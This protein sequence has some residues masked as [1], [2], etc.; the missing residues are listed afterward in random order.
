M[1]DDKRATA[2]DPAA[3]AAE[4]DDALRALT[5]AHMPTAGDLLPLDVIESLQTGMDLLK[6]QVIPFPSERARA[7]QARGMQ[8]VDLDEMQVIMQGD[9][10]DPPLLLSPEM[11]RRMVDQTPLL[12][13]IVM[14]RQR[15][16]SRFCTPSE[17]DGIGF[18][19]RH[20]DATHQLAPEEEASIRRLTRFFSNCGWEWNPRKRK[21]MKRDSFIALMAKLVRD[22]L[23]LDRAAIEAEM[24]RDR[25]LGIDGLYAIDGATLRL[26]T[27]AGFRGD[28]NIRALQVV[29]GRIATAYDADSLI[30]EA[31]NP[32][33]DVRFGD[34]GFS[35]LEVL[36]QTI[37]GF[38]NAMTLNIAG[39]NNNTIPKGMLHLM[40]EYGDEELAAFKRYWGAMLRGAANAWQ[41]PV[42]VS[43]DPQGK[44]QFEKFGVDFNE[45]YFG[46]WMTFLAS[47]SCAVYSM[48]PA[49]INFE[50]FTN[51]TSSLSGSDTEEKLTASKDKGLRP[52]LSYFEGL[53]TD[54]VVQ[55]FGDKYCFRWIGLDPKDE[56]RDWEARKLVLTVNE[57]R[58]RLGEK[59]HEDDKIGNAPLNPSLIGIYQQS[60]QPQGQDFGGGGDD[61]GAPSQGGPEDD[62]PDGAEGDEQ[63]VPGED[64]GGGGA[65]DDMPAPDE[66]DFGKAL[67]TIYAI[68]G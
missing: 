61:Y 67:P 64:Q 11:A 37:T 59:A 15:Q 36:V 43:R 51:G 30:F 19:I 5:R 31:R 42:M 44:A 9:Y 27:D 25:S 48:D 18:A 62:D 56:A 68:G 53:F 47:M 34:Y 46:K 41:L 54:Y 8:S 2:F 4:R 24:K 16:I 20:L 40:G 63:G 50:S 23:T 21:G 6:A 13:A 39:F 3:P 29:N 45:M 55:D 66:P 22:S 57:L 49:E 17:D 38:L 1:A 28:P 58:A 12:S 26:C 33:A 32:R 7:P 52:L 10:Y 35:E 14:T 60:I 65:P